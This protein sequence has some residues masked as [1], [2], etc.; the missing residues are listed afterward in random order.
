MGRSALANHCVVSHQ[1]IIRV[2]SGFVWAL[3]ASAVP[4]RAGAI[5]RAATK[6][7]A[8]TLALPIA[9]A[10]AFLLALALA[11][12]VAVVRAFLSHAAALTDF[13]RRTR[14]PTLAASASGS[15]LG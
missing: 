14:R 3:A 13:A 15:L 6:S 12:T 2:E 7:F 1:A 11:R 10:M 8:L 5:A 9:P 4:P